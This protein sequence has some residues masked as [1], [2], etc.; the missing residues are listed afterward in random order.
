[1]I[2]VLNDGYIRLVDSMG[3][4][5]SIIR[6]ARVS[7]DGDTRTGVDKAGDAKLMGF[8]YRNGHNTPFES[9]SVQFEVKAPIFV[10]RQWMRHRTW[11][12]NEVS[13]RYTELEE[14]YFVPEIGD[15]GVQSTRNKQASMRNKGTVTRDTRVQNIIYH[16]NSESF[17]TYKKLL[18]DGV[19]REIARSVLP[20]AMY[21][22]MYAKVDLSNLFKFLNE[23]LAEDAQ[24]E[25]RVYAEAIVKLVEPVAPVAVAAFLKSRETQD[26]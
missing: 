10:L 7:H 3:D 8:L 20:L 2:E 23:R 6:S 21:T 15:I 11:S 4:D 25:I 26:E 24:P 19:P 13:A 12:Y 22:R 5:N 17:E 14:T 1:M 9:V 18:V 16:A